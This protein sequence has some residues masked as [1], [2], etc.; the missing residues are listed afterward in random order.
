VTVVRTRGAR[1]VYICLVATC[2][3]TAQAGPPYVTDDPE[4]TDIHQFENY[5]YVQGTNAA[6]SFQS[7]GV[8]LEI[9]YGAFANTQL[10]WSIPLNPNPGPGG[11]GL[12]WAPLGG[13]IKYRF[14]EED[15]EGWRPQVAVFPQIFI[16]VGSASRSSP[17]TELLPIWLQKSFGAWTAF[18]GGGYTRNP[19][20]N[21]T[22][23]AI[24]GWALQRQINPKLALGVELFGQTHDTAADR[25]STAAGFA[26]LYDL[27]KTWHLIGSV[28]TSVAGTAEN[29]QFSFNFALKWTQ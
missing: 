13:G 27:N 9:N 20:A 28:N 19:G 26:A 24:Y 12:V 7:P 6:G 17:T 14:V 21:N 25:G 29:D 8:G 23:F 11:M 3:P 16:P 15:S 18:G 22:N 1:F 4:P 5:L 2:T 10:S